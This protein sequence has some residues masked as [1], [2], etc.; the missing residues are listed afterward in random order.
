MKISECCAEDVPLLDRHMPEAGAG[1]HHARRFARQADGRS[2][3]LLAWRDGVP[4]GSCEVRWDGCAAPEVQ[5]A[6]PGMPEVNGLGVWPETLRSESTANALIRA[7]EARSRERGCSGAGLGVE[8]NN[9]RAEALYER[10]GY[11]AS[12]PYLDC[13][14]Y[15]DGDGVT[16]R[17]AD[18]CVFLVKEL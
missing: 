14:S 11:R 18:A 6:H 10:L 4:V 5:A 3:Y 16:H 15:E 12:T 9:P 17:V 13:W 7:A 2:T 8:R 1:S